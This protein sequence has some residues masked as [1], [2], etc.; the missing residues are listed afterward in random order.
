[1]IYNAY[2][3][4]IFVFPHL[5]LAFPAYVSRRNDPRLG[6]VFALHPE[7]NCRRLRRCDGLDDLTIEYN[8]WIGLREKLQE[9]PIFNGNIY[10]FL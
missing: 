2:I 5:H 8:Q 10:G 7:R 1:M 9:S 3:L 4:M 6:R